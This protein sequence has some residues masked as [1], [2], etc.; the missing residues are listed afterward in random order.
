M[1]SVIFYGASNTFGVGLHT[2]R[3]IYLNET[4]V[5]FI[6]WPYN[7]TDLDNDFIEKNRWTG[8]VANYINRNEI[9]IS[10]VGGSPAAMLYELNKTDLTDVDYIFFEFS[11]IYNYFDKFIHG[12]YY[13]KTPHEI[14]M[15]LT[16]GKKDK[17]ELRQRIIEWLKKYKPIEFIEEVLE[18][19]K[20]K[21]ENELSDK[22]II[23][24]FW[25][26]ALEGSNNN[27]NSEKYSWLKKYIVKFPTKKNID[28][29]IVHN[30][31]LEEKLTVSHEHPLSHLFLKDIHAGLKGNKRV[32][33]IVINHIN[34]KEITNS[35]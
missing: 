16:N 12:E 3:P 20:Y 7:Q 14:E 1:K 19:F 17:P 26:N 4:G 34:E 23:I 29:N 15:F 21:I 25:H 18:L 24:L 27:I 8:K 30:L 35:W 32:A 22:K 31:L 5:K 10:H 13:P 33:E 9:N 6:N 28:N 2:F 11:G